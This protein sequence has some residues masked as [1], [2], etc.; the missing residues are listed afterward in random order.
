MGLADANAKCRY[1]CTVYIFI[2]CQWAHK[3][4]MSVKQ[5]LYLVRVTYILEWRPCSRDITLLTLAI[6]RLSIIPEEDS[7]SFNSAL[8]IQHTIDEEIESKAQMLFLHFSSR[9]THQLKDQLVQ[10]VNVEDKKLQNLQNLFIHISTQILFSTSKCIKHTLIKIE[11][12]PCSLL[13]LLYILSVF[14]LS[15]LCYFRF[16]FFRVL[17]NLMQ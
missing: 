1:M 7:S 9:H 2:Q 6:N 12:I 10:N 8:N 15:R 3:N 4:S 5:T 11:Y 16:G 14:C 13:L 17:H